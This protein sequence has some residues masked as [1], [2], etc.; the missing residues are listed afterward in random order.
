MFRQMPAL[1]VGRSLA[2]A[3]TK[4]WALL[5]LRSGHL[6]EAAD[7]GFAQLLSATVGRIGTRD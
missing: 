2:K 4:A 6:S 5:N 3:S 7:T 1:T